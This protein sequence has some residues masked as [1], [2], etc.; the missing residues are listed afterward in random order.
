MTLGVTSSRVDMSSLSSSAWRA[1]SGCPEGLRYTL[2]KAVN[3][4]PPEWLQEPTTGEIFS[5]MD[6]AHSRLIAFSLSQGFDVVISHSSQK[7]Q[8][9]T[10]FSCTH[11]GTKTK[12]WRKLPERVEKDEQGNIVGERKLNLTVVRQTGCPWACRVSYKNVGKRGSGE[13]GYIL[14]VKSVSHDNTHPLASNPLVYQRHRERLIEYQTIKAQA[15]AHRVSVLPY[16]LSRRVLDSVDSSGLSLTRKEYY[17]LKKLSTLNGKD[18]STIEGLLYALN[19]AGFIHRCRVEDSFND[20]ST[21]V[22]RKLI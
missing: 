7:P 19:D 22:S 2:E 4:Y 3:A 8:P 12:N 1:P 17:R 9:V 21:I 14:T 16:S 11:H 10:T 18:D 20:S 15:Q 6:E 5:S 13:R